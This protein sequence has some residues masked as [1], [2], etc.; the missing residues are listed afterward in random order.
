MKTKFQFWKKVGVLFLC[1]WAIL[2]SEGCGSTIV[3]SCEDGCPV[4][5]FPFMDYKSIA[6][7][8]NQLT[9]APGE[10][11]FL[12]VTAQEIEFIACQ[13]APHHWRL[14]L[15]NS[16]LACSC[17]GNGSNGD[18]FT[19]E[20]VNLYADKPFR[21]GMPI[22]MSLNELF[23]VE[24]RDNNG[25]RT[26]PLE[27]VSTNNPIRLNGSMMLQGTARPDKLDQAY[28]LTI[29]I[30]KSNGERLTVDTE[31]ITWLP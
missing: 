14:G 5:E 11:L 26:T 23:S 18:K 3:D 21:S 28:V 8:P 7:N 17:V 30:L 6:A 2:L 19:I 20:A 31:P 1:Y 29:E 25:F 13:D 10:A 16:A 27:E 12:N 15:L 22:D 9:I 24:S 4:V